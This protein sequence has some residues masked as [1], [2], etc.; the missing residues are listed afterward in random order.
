MSI[1]SSSGEALAPVPSSAP[2]EE[3]EE[4]A[5]SADQVTAGRTACLVHELSISPANSTL[6]CTQ[7]TDNSMARKVMPIDD[8]E[9][10]SSTSVEVADAVSQKMQ[11]RGKRRR[12]ISDAEG[13]IQ[14]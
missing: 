13:S 9:K 10:E 5:P 4:T 1:S 14:S 12:S 2:V 8:H 6:H 11:G 7:H 3:S